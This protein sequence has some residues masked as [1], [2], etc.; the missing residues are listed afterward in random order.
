VIPNTETGR[1]SVRACMSCAMAWVEAR[2][3][4]ESLTYREIVQN[5]TFNRC[6]HVRSDG[7]HVCKIC[8][9]AFTGSVLLAWSYA[10]ANGEGQDANRLHLVIQALKRQHDRAVTAHLSAKVCGLSN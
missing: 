4:D 10:R 6:A 2:L 8:L 3:R 9:T 5:V 1:G 7:D